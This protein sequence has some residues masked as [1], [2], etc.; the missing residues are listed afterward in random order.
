MFKARIYI[1][2]SLSV[3]RHFHYLSAPTNE[4]YIVGH[5][6]SFKIGCHHCIPVFIS[7][8]FHSKHFSSDCPLFHLPSFVCPHFKHLR[9]HITI[10]HSVCA[11]VFLSHLSSYLFMHNV[12]VLICS[13]FF[14]ICSLITLGK[15]SRID[16]AFAIS[17]LIKLVDCSC[18]DHAFQT[19]SI[20]AIFYHIKVPNA[21]A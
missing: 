2:E 7:C 9:L 6:C 8:L 5:S 3:C 21:H 11:V 15:C 17:Y 4:T 19:F 18:E 13:H 20:F 16:H 1:S 10:C 12:Y 14:A